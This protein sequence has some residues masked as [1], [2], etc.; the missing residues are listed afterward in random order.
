M[1]AQ[2]P[3][4]F[5]CSGLTYYVYKNAAG[6]KLPRQSSAQ[7]K[8]GTTITKNNLK[9]GD[10]V[11]FSKKDS[12][13]ISHVGIYIG[14]GEMIHAPNK[15]EPVKIESLQVEC[16]KMNFVRGKRVL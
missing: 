12:K 2:G 8:F 7:G 1:G 13:T 11:F 10:L 4:S 6:I 16:K 3:N 15:K 9:P 5:D 14:N